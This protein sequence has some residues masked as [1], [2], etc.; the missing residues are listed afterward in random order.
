MNFKLVHVGSE[1][2][3]HCVC[4]RVHAHLHGKISK[5]VAQLSQEIEV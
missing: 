3:Q 2:S 5:A 4:L 1:F